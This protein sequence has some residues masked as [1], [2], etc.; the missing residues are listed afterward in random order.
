M[1]AKSNFVLKNRTWIRR[2]KKDLKIWRF[3][4]Y[5]YTE[6]VTEK[7]VF[8]IFSGWPVLPRTAGSKCAANTGKFFYRWIGPS[9][10]VARSLP[11]SQCRIKKDAEIIIFKAL[12]LFNSLWNC[13]PDFFGIHTDQ[14]YT[15]TL[16][17]VFVYYSAYYS[18]RDKCPTIYGIRSALG[19]G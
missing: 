6:C 11:F 7:R 19:K 8:V 17:N 5:I 15:H 12:Q 4:K 13:R 2:G 18:R 14:T 9:S 3:E 10:S 16:Y 1:H